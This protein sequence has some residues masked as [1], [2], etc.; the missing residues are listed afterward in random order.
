MAILTAKDNHHAMTKAS[1]SV[2]KNH[3]LGKTP[4]IDD[5]AALVLVQPLFH[6]PLC[7]TWLAIY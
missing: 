2:R 1:K 4:G 6:T 7:S 5:N 3:F